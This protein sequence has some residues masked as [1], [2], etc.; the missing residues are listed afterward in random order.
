MTR[1]ELAVFLLRYAGFAGISLKTDAV[2]DY[3]DS[4][5]I[6]PWA[7]LAVKRAGAAGLIAERSGHAF[8]P[9]ADATRA[10]VADALVHLI[11]NMER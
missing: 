4:D 1:Q 9:T 5:R 2:P 3:A 8:A 11:E 7:E 10:E 6:A